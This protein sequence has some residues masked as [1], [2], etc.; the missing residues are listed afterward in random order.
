MWPMIIGAVASALINKSSS[1]GSSSSGGGEG[2]NQASQQQTSSREPWSAAVPWLTEN[3]ASGQQLQAGYKANPFS[4]MQKQSYNNQFGNSDYYRSMVDSVLGQQNQ[5][6]PFDRSNPYA[7]PQTY[8]MPSRTQ[9][10]MPTSATPY[11]M[12]ES[13]F[14]ATNSGWSQ[15]APAAAPAQ[16]P[17]GSDDFDY[18][19]WRYGRE[20]ATNDPNRASGQNSYFHYKNFWPAEKQT[21]AAM[22]TLNQGL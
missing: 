6:K 1:G 10:A 22:T 2:G 21:L 19:M 7:K 8:Q 5:Q 9:P 4:A 18:N 17:E 12:V 3:I 11:S 15:P 16:A 13:P 14:S 20:Q